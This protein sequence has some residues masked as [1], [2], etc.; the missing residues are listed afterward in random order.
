[1]YIIFRLALNKMKEK[2]VKDDGEPLRIAS[3]TGE[4]N[5]I[6][7]TMSQISDGLVA[8]CKVYITKLYATL[9]A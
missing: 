2:M 5:S 7:P 4:Q 9:S 6:T 1:M 8:V 3:V